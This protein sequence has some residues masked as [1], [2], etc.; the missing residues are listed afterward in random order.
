MSV[1]T[2]LTDYGPGSEHVGALHAVI[3]S[4]CP[5][6]DRIDL[7]HDIPPGDVTFGA[8]VLARL[9]PL[10]PPAVHLAVVDPGVGTD[11]RGVAV[12]CADGSVVVGPDNGLLGPAC[13]ALGGAVAAVQ[14][15]SRAHRREPVAP[16]FHGRDVFAPA[17]AFLACGGAL[18]QLGPHVVPASIA[19]PVLPAPAVAP[20]RLEATILGS[21]RFGNIQLLA[22]GGDLARAFP[23]GGALAVRVGGAGALQCAVGRVFADAARGGGLVYVDG[24][25]RVAV[26]V[27]DGRAS[28]AVDATP[29]ARALL[30]RGEPARP[31]R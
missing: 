10:A 11:R 18:S 21:D 31:G 2:L 7:A 9:A 22:G 25:G 13:A 27:R 23:D 3:A 1:V 15:I 14:I 24:D 16:T 30:E 6:A 28:D 26:A 20:G 4:G 19:H 5:G 17:A 8:M 29:G 12:S